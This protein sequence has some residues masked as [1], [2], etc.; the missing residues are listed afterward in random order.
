MEAEIEALRKEREEKVRQIA[1]RRRQVEELRKRRSER[2]QQQREAK[3]EP[4][5]L[6]KNVDILVA[7]ILGGDASKSKASPEGPLREL[8]EKSRVAPAE[9]G[10][11]SLHFQQELSIA[12]VA[13]EPEG[14][15]HYDR[16]CQT[17]LHG[18]EV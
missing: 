8:R 3:L 10:E 1:E 4:G 5:D 7:E 15:E 6:N 16:S 18:D 14:A 9:P 13:V 2:Q 17:D 12:S 11:R